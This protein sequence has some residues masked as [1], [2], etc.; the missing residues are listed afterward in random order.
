M[1]KFIYKNIDNNPF[2]PKVHGNE[3][4]DQL[5]Y[6]V[7][8]AYDASSLIPYQRNMM[9][10]DAIKFVKFGRFAKH[11]VYLNKN[12]MERLFLLAKNAVVTSTEMIITTKQINML[13]HTIDEMLSVIAESYKQHITADT[14]S[15]GSPS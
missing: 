14:S 13:S 5:I 1:S 2:I 3:S 12:I 15:V 10:Y 8:R 11:H 4:D 6:Y 7:N 9:L